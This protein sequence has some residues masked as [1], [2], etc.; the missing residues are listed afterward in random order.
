[1]RL[2]LPLLG[3]LLFAPA[4]TLAQS[5]PYGDWLYYQVPAD[6]DAPPIYVVETAQGVRGISVI[7]S[8]VGAA[9]PEESLLLLNP[10]F[11]GMTDDQRFDAVF[12][13][14]KS[15]QRDYADAVLDPDPAHATLDVVEGLARVLD[16]M[17]HYEA[18]IITQRDVAITEIAIPLSGFDD[19]L[20]RARRDCGAE[21]S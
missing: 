18:F 3:G 7:Y 8:C 2:L 17:Q 13:F 1:M 4:I 14:G 19:A 5:Q 9:T 12:T 21:S 20:Q 10:G 16:G 15:K 11:S 6:G